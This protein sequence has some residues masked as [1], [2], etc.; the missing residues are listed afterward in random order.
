MAQLFADA[1]SDTERLIDLC[2]FIP[3]TD[4]RAAHL[5]TAAAASAFIR[6]NL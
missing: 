3:N 5:H 6:I 1:A 4:R 2:F